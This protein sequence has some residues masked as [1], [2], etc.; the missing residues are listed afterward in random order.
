VIA[1][2]RVAGQSAGGLRMTPADP[3][4]TVG[5]VDLWADPATGLPLMVEI[6]GRG[7]ARPALE[8]KFFQVSRWR[9]DPRVLT[10]VRANGTGFTVTSASN[11]A[12]ALSDLGV[13][14][15]PGQLAGRDR[16]QVPEGFEAIG[17]YGGGL[18]TFVVLGVRGSAGRN[19]VADTLS[20]G[21]TALGIQG[22]SGALISAP[23][24]NAVLVR[25]AGWSL[26]YLIAG[27]VDSGLLEQAAVTLTQNASL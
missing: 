2:L 9:P 19:L 26:T 1:P 6:F 21:G 18:A 4:S 8:S 20:A 27:T 22:G 16:L 5:R 23:L 17:V 15:L 14:A 13:L 3:A 25:P 10:P 11:L 24:I 7:S 12:G